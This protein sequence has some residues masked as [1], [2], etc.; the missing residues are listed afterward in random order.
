MTTGRA[1]AHAVSASPSVPDASCPDASY[2]GRRAGTTRP[3]CCSPLGGTDGP[4]WIRLYRSG[5]AEPTSVRAPKAAD[6][7][8]LARGSCQERPSSVA[9]HPWPGCAVETNLELRAPSPSRPRPRQRRSA[10]HPPHHPERPD[11]RLRAPCASAAAQEFSDSRRQDRRGL[12][13]ASRNRQ[14]S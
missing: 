13:G 10:G 4:M 7:A 9:I 2:P 6:V 11:G 1:G 8:V 3:P 5:R 12:R 14:M